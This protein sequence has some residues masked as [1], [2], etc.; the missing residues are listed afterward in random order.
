[1][2]MNL[3][4]RLTLIRLIAV[5]F[6]MAVMLVPL[7]TDWSSLT[8]SILSLVGAAMFIGAAVTDLLDGRIARKN[9]LITDFGKFL[10]PLADKFMVIGAM[11]CVLYATSVAGRSALATIYFFA[12]IIVIFRE[13]AV[14]SIRLI[15]SS[16]NGVVIAA[17]ILGKLKTVLQIVAISAA[18][19]EPVLQASLIRLIPIPQILLEFPP[20]TLISTV[21]MIYFTIH[22]GIVYIVNAWKYL[23][24]T[25]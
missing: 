25:K 13:L 1:M 4:N 21:L 2:K 14:T 22:S 15:A 8:D 17:N 20:I 18:I 23:D 7:F 6:F 12:L 5:P 19:I 11:L 24:H 16:S 9:G 10:D 3:P